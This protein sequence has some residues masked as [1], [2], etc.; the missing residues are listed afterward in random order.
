MFT[1]AVSLMVSRNVLTELC[2]AL[3]NLDDTVS[4]ATGRFILDKIQ[5]RVISFEDQVM[6]ML[7][8]KKVFIC[9]SI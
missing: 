6:D 3:P 7:D 1:N 2:T 8:A 9:T 4:E 5:Q